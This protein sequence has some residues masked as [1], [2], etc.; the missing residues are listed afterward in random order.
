MM[1]TTTAPAASV[2]V[3]VKAASKT[4]SKARRGAARMM[5]ATASKR[6][7][8][9]SAGPACLPVSVLEKAQ[10]EMLDWHG[11]GMSVMEMSH[12]GKEYTSI[13]QK[14]EADLRALVGIPDHYKVMFIQGGASTQ[15][16]ALPF[17]LTGSASDK[18]DYVLTGAWGKKAHQEAAR[19]CDAKVVASSK[20][21]NFS[22]IPAPSTW[23]LRDDAKYVHVCSNETIGGVEFKSF[24][25]TEAPL[26]ADMSSNFCS[27]PFDMEQFGV[28]YA[29]AQKN[30]G[31]AGVTMV[32]VREDLIGNA[33]AD[34]PTMLDWKT[35]AE[36]D[37]LYNTPSSYAIYMCGLVF[38]DLLEQGGLEAVEKKN[39][40]KAGKLYDV[41]SN[42][43]GF[44]SCP[45]DDAVRSCMNVPFRVVPNDLEPAF[46]DAAKDAGLLSLKGH[47]SVG[48]VRA[49]I[50]NAMPDEGV[51]ALTDLMKDFQAKHA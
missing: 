35:M 13:I 25:K 10:A 4:A 12:R 32:I 41:I 27:K 39:I 7:Y 30:V 50:Y 29:G 6:A 16:A 45:V 11:S 51:D 34:C 8:N 33:R 15:F 38:A 40:A 36:N 19:Y 22:A 21:S 42:S 23:D 43:N 9:F 2:A 17:N 48:G 47:R 20:E 1:Y 3:K 37:S 18:A 44:Y 5:A 28:V 31:P 26:I 49:S 14:A 46:L 24:P